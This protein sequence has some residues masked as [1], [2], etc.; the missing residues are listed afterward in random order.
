[1]SDRFCLPF[2]ALPMWNSQFPPLFMIFVF[3]F[4]F[5]SYSGL[6]SFPES[7]S[8]PYRRILL[9][10]P[11]FYSR[12]FIPPPPA[13][14]PPCGISPF[15]TQG[16]NV[17]FFGNGKINKIPL[18]IGSPCASFA[19]LCSFLVLAPPYCLLFL[20]CTGPKTTI[21]HGLDSSF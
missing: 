7:L 10:V 20:G 3:C 14:F 5:S 12:L 17:G 15:S 13:L 18:P 4:F 16:Q 6:S 21:V 1:M 2:L 19:A 9:P 11:A 8:T